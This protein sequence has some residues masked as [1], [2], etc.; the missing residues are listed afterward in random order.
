MVESNIG[1]VAIIGIAFSLL[2][3]ACK[4]FLPST[5]NP[6]FLLFKSGSPLFLNNL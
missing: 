6:K 3:H 1:D 4:T 2:E 5:A